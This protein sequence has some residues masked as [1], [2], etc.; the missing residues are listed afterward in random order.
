MKKAQVAREAMHDLCA[1][2]RVMMDLK[3]G[4]KVA[5]IAAIGKATQKDIDGLGL[6][7]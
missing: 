1:A 6:E 4:K 2:H 3:D 5:A 7:R